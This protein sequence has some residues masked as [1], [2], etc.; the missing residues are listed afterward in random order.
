MSKHY[1]FVALVNAKDGQDAAFN[2]WHTQTHL[3]EVV[4]AAGFTRGERFK[5]VDGSNGE[6]TV[7]RYL[8]IFEGQGD[9]MQAL[10]KLGAAVNSGAVHMSDSLGA[11]IWASMYEVI[12]DAQ[13]S[14]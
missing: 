3:P 9:P 6:N 11:P 10:M 13:V 12:P 14:R 2:A 4:R 8:V 1:K 7:Y 5:L